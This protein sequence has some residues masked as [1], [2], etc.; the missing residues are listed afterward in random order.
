MDICQARSYRTI[1]WLLRNSAD[2]E[3]DVLKVRDLFF[4]LSVASDWDTLVAL[5]QKDIQET[6]WIYASPLGESADS[7]ISRVQVLASSCP[8]TPSG[9]VARCFPWPNGNRYTTGTPSGPR[10]SSRTSSRFF[11]RGHGEPPFS[12]HSQ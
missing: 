7:V 2:Q 12:F 11:V 5:A 3:R 9:T 10:R 6:N 1:S 8:C 4:L